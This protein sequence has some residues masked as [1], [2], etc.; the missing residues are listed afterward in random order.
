MTTDRRQ[1]YRAYHEENRERRLVQS[2]EYYQHHRDR[3]RENYSKNRETILAGQRD[4]YKR[5]GVAY[6]AKNRERIIANVKKYNSK[7]AAKILE[8][9]RANDAA[10]HKQALDI[11]GH[12]C[13]CSC[14]CNESADGALTLAHLMDDGKADRIS[15]GGRR[16]VFQAAITHPDHEKYATRCWVCN[17]G[18]Y[19]NGGTC[20]RLGNGKKLAI[21]IR[22]NY[23]ILHK[24]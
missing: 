6:Y 3:I 1:Y 10:L 2:R 17:S 24:Q 16:E 15:L 11:Y 5:N 8:H 18:A 19:M 20:P 9:R 13:T 21:S 23:Q 12:K 14:G 4:W 7:N 22:K